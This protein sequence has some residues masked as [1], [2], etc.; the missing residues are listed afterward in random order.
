M[1]RRGYMLNRN[2]IALAGVGLITAG[3]LIFLAHSQVSDSRSRDGGIARADTVAEAIDMFKDE[4]FN[5]EVALKAGGPKIPLCSWPPCLTI[6]YP[7]RIPTSGR[8]SS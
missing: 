3:A 8:P 7:F 5:P 1:S 4:G 2:T 6:S